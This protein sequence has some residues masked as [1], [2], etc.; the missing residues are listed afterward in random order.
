[1]GHR[2]AEA[3]EGGDRIPDPVGQPDATVHHMGFDVGVGLFLCHDE[4]DEAVWPRQE[5]ERFLD[6]VN[7]CLRH[8][9]LPDHREPRSI[10]EI[11][12]P[13]PP[14]TDPCLFGVSMGSY[15]S[16]SRRAERL[17]WFA[18][19]VAVRGTAPSA[20]SYE[21]ELHDAYDELPDRR[22]T[23][24]HLLATCGDG[25][26]V[27]PRPLDEVIY[28]HSSGEYH[29][30]VSAHRLWAESVALG[31]VLRTGDPDGDDSPVIDRT[32]GTPVWDRSFA[33]LDA[34]VPEDADAWEHWLD[35][36]DLCRRLRQ[37]ATEVLRTGAL[38]LT[39]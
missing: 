3:A 18:R 1:M 28:D 8:H 39:G 29:C 7:A 17:A 2:R 26:V 32:A 33:A 35:E 12:P 6:E 22:L 24:D 27:L 23:F 5:K 13:L 16:H 11:D 38:G 21:P 20:R 34:R 30:L 4:E 10:V 36:S 9:G 31:F 15:S 14:E 19:Y 37:T 25:V